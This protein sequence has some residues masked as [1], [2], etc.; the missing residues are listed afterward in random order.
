M[1]SNGSDPATIMGRLFAGAPGPRI[2][3]AMVLVRS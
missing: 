3:P 2:S 1:G